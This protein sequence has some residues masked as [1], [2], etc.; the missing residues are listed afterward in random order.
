[1]QLFLT[2]L[3]GSLM[4]LLLSWAEGLFQLLD[5]IFLGSFF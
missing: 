3:G 1:M 2:L 5:P 4:I